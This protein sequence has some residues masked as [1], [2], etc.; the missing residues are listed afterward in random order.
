MSS[1]MTSTAPAV[2]PAESEGERSQPQ[3]TSGRTATAAP[4]DPEVRRTPERRHFSAEYKQRILAECDRATAPGQIGAILRREGLFSFHLRDSCRASAGANGRA[5][6]PAPRPPVQVADRPR[7]GVG[8]SAAREGTAGRET[9]AG[10][11][12]HRA[13]KKVSELLGVRLPQRQRDG[14]DEST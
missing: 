1:A 11:A 13:A 3:R 6:T 7:R 5:G 12:D 2:L 14:K 9:P 10:G 4:P 8:G